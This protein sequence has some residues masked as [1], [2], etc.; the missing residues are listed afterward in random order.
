[1]G[2]GSSSS[3]GVNTGGCSPPASSRRQPYP[4]ENVFDPTGAGS[5]FAG[6]FLGVLAWI[7]RLG[8]TAL[9]H[10]ALVGSVM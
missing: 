9:K 3:K 8:V 2:P 5:T 4:L 10:A 6:G 1:M 7:E